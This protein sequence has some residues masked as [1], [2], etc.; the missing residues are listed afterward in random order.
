MIASPS[1]SHRP[2]ERS[3]HSLNSLEP[4][5][6]CTRSVVFLDAAVFF[7]RPTPNSLR[8]AFCAFL[9]DLL[10][11]YDVRAVFCVPTI[12]QW[13]STT[14]SRTP[15]SR[16]CSSVPS[17]RYCP[18]LPSLPFCR[19]VVRLRSASV[20]RRTLPTPAQAAPSAQCRSGLLLRALH[21]PPSLLID[22]V[23][24]R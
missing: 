13:V 2:T 10:G 9:L 16:A 8:S 5:T 22:G 6:T 23:N 24:A 21:A 4:S 17:W 1:T 11:S 7:W 18:P 3:L 19:R 14:F 20:A 12:V 15:F